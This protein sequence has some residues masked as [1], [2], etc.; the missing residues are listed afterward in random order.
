MEIVM[1]E[2]RTYEAM[3]S[4]FEQFIRRV[5]VL[6]RQHMDYGTKKWLDSQEVCILLD[7]SKRTLQSLRDS[8][9][10]GYSM[11]GHKIFY[12]PSDVQAM[13]DRLVEEREVRDGQ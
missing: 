7:I 8:G 1:I 11:I 6:C 13:I 9:K 4:K 5:D 12:R 2:A 10:L 3:M